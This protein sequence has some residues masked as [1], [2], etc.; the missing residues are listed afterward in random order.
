M[1]SD[2]R[3]LSFCS[4][5]GD[6]SL[7]FSLRTGPV[8]VSVS[9]C[10]DVSNHP[11][12]DAL[13]VYA[14]P[15]RAGTAAVPPLPQSTTGVMDDVPPASALEMNTMEALAACSSLLGH[16][17]NFA[18]TASTPAIVEQE[19]KAK[20]D[21]LCRELAD[22]A[23]SVLRK[24]CLA[25][26]RARWRALRASCRSLLAAAQP[27]AASRVDSVTGA[28]AGEILLALVGEGAGG[29]V[30]PGGGVNEG[31]SSMSMPT[32]PVRLTRL[33]QLCGYVCARRPKLLLDQLA[34]A[35][36]KSGESYTAIAG[37]DSGGDGSGGSISNDIGSR[38]RRQFGRFVFPALLRRFWESCV[39]RRD[40]GETTQMVL[41]CV[42]NLAVHEMR[43]AG[44]AAA[45]ASTVSTVD[46]GVSANAEEEFSEQEVLRAGLARLMPLL[47]SSVARVSQA[48]SEYLGTL[49][50]G[51][52]PAADGS[53]RS[54]PPT[55]VSQAAAGRRQPESFGAAKASAQE[56][57]DASLESRASA[58]VVLGTYA[59]SA[60]SASEAEAEAEA[61]S[62]PG[63]DSDTEADRK[64]SA[65]TSV[66]LALAGLRRAGHLSI[67]V[68]GGGRAGGRS[69]LGGGGGGD[70][71]SPGPT[72]S[73]SSAAAPM[74]HTAFEGLVPGSVKR[75]R[76]SSS[77]S[78]AGV[79]P[80]RDLAP[81][82]DVAGRADMDVVGGAADQDAS[83]SVP[84]IA[85]AGREQA[86]RSLG[87]AAAPGTGST[88][89]GTGAAA[90]ASSKICYRCDG[91]DDF[92][93]QHVRYHCKVCPDFDLCPQCYEVF[94]GPNSQFQ[95]GNAVMLR[96]HS[97]SHEMVAL[98]VCGQ[99]VFEAG[100]CW[101]SCFGVASM[102]RCC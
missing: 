81:R 61:T 83:S 60:A 47:Q 51:T 76:T 65:V 9:S 33:A 49:L 91:C 79:V 35:L 53:P 62:D 43:A 74:A 69:S 22:S 41:R 99:S 34:P 14:R 85:S 8:V 102:A 95:G 89:R 93:L 66:Q 94:H 80:G 55:A 63:T 1:I 72:D 70:N 37:G 97:T 31:S 6:T 57:G 32:S 17:L 29:E 90:A 28:Y 36:A 18:G 100:G 84:E 23:L 67:P 56:R 96:D 44:T 39:W 30:A 20:T 50:L 88:A 7:A 101:F 27:D 45:A 46:N 82:G 75:A 10:T 54:S 3:C 87:S 19:Q 98:E 21:T 64:G 40:G 48:S 92:P 26:D 15:H 5:D 78:A 86:R 25:A 42:L 16:T 2:I 13:E 71:P 58:G 73:L 59:A 52:L 77:S 24:T 11:L 68:G 38:P 12:I 4:F